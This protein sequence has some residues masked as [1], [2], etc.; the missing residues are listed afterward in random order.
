[1]LF[2]IVPMFMFKD[3]VLDCACFIAQILYVRSANPG[4]RGACT[5]TFG[6]LYTYVYQYGM[7]DVRIR[8]HNSYCRMPDTAQLESR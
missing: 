4:A 7:T 3:F 6:I 5:I 8:F 1:M 2:G